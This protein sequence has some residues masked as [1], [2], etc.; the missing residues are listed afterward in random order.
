ML[1]HR[2]IRSRL[3]ALAAVV[4]LGAAPADRSPLTFEVTYT[5]DAHPGPISARVYVLLGPAGQ[6][7]EPRHGPDWFKPQPFFA[8]EAKDW[9][10]GE[11]LLVGADAVG[12]PGPLDHIKP[13]RIRDP[14]GRPAQPGHPC[15]RRRA[16]AT[17]TGRSSA[18][19][20]TPRP[21]ARSRLTVNRVVP[22]RKFEETDRIRLVDIAEPAPVGVPSPADPASRGGDLARGGH[23]VEASRRSTSCPGSAATTTWP[24]GSPRAGS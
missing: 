13:G 20:S 11:P 19:R 6:G 9:M 16:R 2:L 15:A 8:V 22:P 7:R 21:A 4:S 24:I 3:A 5:A 18:P 10:A 17:P 12:F 14:G 1:R 23:G